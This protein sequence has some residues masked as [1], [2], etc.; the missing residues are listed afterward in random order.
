MAGN[1]RDGNTKVIPR[2]METQYKSCH[3]SSVPTSDTV[4]L[5]EFASKYMN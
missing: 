2:G 4:S 1:E 3:M 5:A